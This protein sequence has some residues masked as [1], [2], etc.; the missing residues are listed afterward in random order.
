MARASRT[1]RIFVSSTF[2]DLKEERNALQEHV[3]PKL[4]ELC[5]RHGARFQ[6]IDLRWGVSEEAGLD[7]RTMNICLDEIERCRKT[8][9]RPN[10]IVLLGD[11]YGW[12]PLPAQVE[13]EEFKA[14][15]DK[16][17]EPDRELLLWSDSQPDDQKGWYRRDDN[18]LPPVYCLRPREINVP[19]GATDEEKKAAQDKEAAQWEQTEQRLRSILLKAVEGMPLEAYD[20][21]KYEASA[22]EQEIDRGAVRVPD[23]REHV[24][25]F[26]RKIKDAPEDESAKDFLD[27]VKEGDKWVA[28]N[29]ARTRLKELKDKLRGLFRDNIYEYEARWAGG[30]TTTDH[31]GTLP[32][33]LEEC[34]ELREKADAPSNLCVDVWRGLSRI[35][36]EEI[37]RLEVEDALRKEIADHDAFGEDRA[38]F[39]T[40]RA[41]ILKTIGDYVRGANRHPLAIW[42]ESGSGKS[43]LMARAAQEIHSDLP[44]AETVIRFIGWTPESS[45]IRSLLG[46]VCLQISRAYGAD[47][48]TVPTDYKELVDD[49]PKRLALA[50]AEKPLVLFL[51]ALDQ[52]SDVEQGRGLVWLPADL[53]EHVRLIVSS[54]PGECRS[55]LENKLPSTNLVE[56]EPMPPDEGRKLLDLWL[57]D[58][59]RTLQDH[60]RDE[61]LRKFELSGMPLYLRLA[62]QEAR[63]WKSYIDPKETILRPD[64][65]GIIRDN[66]FARLA[67]D[68]NHGETLLSRSL[69]YLVAA[70]NG[71]SED[72]MLDVLSFDKQVFQD[73]VDRARHK[74]PEERLPVVIWSRLYFDLEPYLTERTADGA[75]LMTFYHRQL[76][77]AVT[78]H[79]LAGREKRDRHRGLARY[80]GNQALEIERAPNLRKMS[81]LPYQQTLGEMWDELYAT[82]TDF[83]FL[84]RKSAEVG[85]LERTDPQGKVTRAYTGVFL[86]QD[87]FRLALEKWPASGRS[88]A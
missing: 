1:F 34:L 88:Q 31:M 65:P 43:A 72:E 84:E 87:D 80:F 25:C 77:E 67:S 55:A 40:G 73:F 49:F 27:L 18:A 41:G 68:V 76:S 14:I 83:R 54:L 32:D 13:V 78:E 11:R 51:D 44:R 82:L 60:Q 9:P 85:V 61:V 20:R 37:A 24:F 29:D 63:L 46:S 5:M 16:L 3:F 74:P 50:T 7:Q 8:T 53:P 69:G 6:A 57:E 48:A 36:E 58:A 19:E 15:L 21:M 52:L 10:F 23:A 38:K 2:N 59:A 30:R 71:L 22:T 17:S 86:L 28:D 75:S 47:E 62:F 66:L 70:K 56:L 35:I 81:E 39:F 79:Y 45:D 4:R 26:F 42:G 64:I 33:T 12:R